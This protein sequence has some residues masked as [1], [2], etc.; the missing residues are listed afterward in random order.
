MTEENIGDIHNIHNIQKNDSGLISLKQ[1]SQISGYTLQHLSHLCREEKLK[2]VR[3]GKKWFTTQGWIKYYFK[4]LERQYENNGKQIQAE[5]Q[6][7]KFSNET[8]EIPERIE[9]PEKK[10]FVPE[11][12]P[13]KIKIPFAWNWNKIG[14]GFAMAGMAFLIFFSFSA[15]FPQTVFSQLK[16]DASIIYPHAK[17]F[18]ARVYSS[19]ENIGSAFGFA[20]FKTSQFASNI[21]IEMPDITLPEIYLP[22]FNLPK[23]SLPEIHLPQLSFS[24]ISEFELPKVKLPDISLPEIKLP[25]Y[26]SLFE[27]A[28]RQS[29]QFG[30]GLYSASR[31][32]LDGS[33]KIFS[34]AGSAFGSAIFKTSQFVSNI[35]FQL[36]AFEISLSEVHPVR[37]QISKISD[38]VSNLISNGVRLPQLSFSWISEFELPEIKLPKINLSKFSFSLLKLKDSFKE[39]KLFSLSDIS[40]SEIKIPKIS[41]KQIFSSLVFGIDETENKIQL[42]AVS[43]ASVLEDMGG[44]FWES[45]KTF[46]L[47]VNEALE[48]GTKEI[49]NYFVQVIGGIKELAIKETPPS[50]FFIFYPSAEKSGQAEQEPQKPETPTA[51]FSLS[52]LEAVKK[53]LAALRQSG[54]KVEQSVAEWNLERILAGLTPEEIDIKLNQL[55]NKILAQIADLKNLVALRTYS[56]AGATVASNFQAIALTQRIDTLS[57]ATINNATITGTLSGLTDDH[58]PDDITAS[59]YLLLTGG[60][61]T[62]TLSGISIITTGN[63]GIGTTSPYSLLSISN[64]AA[65]AVNTPLFTVASTTAGV[66]TT[67]LMTILA[68]GNVGINTAEPLYKLDVIG[69]IRLSGNL[70]FG[71]IATTTGSMLPSSDNAYDLGSESS[72]WRDI[73]ISRNALVS[74]N[75]GIGSTTP[76][77]K[78]SVAGSG[79]FDGGT[80]IASGFTATSSITAPYFTATGNTASTFPYASS[81]F[82]TASGT[83]STTNLISSGYSTLFFASTTQLTTSGTAS[84]TN[85]VVSGN[86]YLS[87]MTPSSIL[88]AGTNGLISQNNPNLNWNNTTN[89]LAV[90]GN[91]STTQIG[92]TDSAY[93]ATASGNVGIGTTSPFAKLS[94]AGSGYFDGNLTVSNITATG[95]LSTF[96]FSATNASTTNLD[97]SGYLIANNASSTITN[98][99]SVFASSTAITVSETASTTNLVVSG[100]SALGSVQSAIMSLGSDAS[101]DIYYRNSSGYLTRLAGSATPGYI[102]AYNAN[103]I[104]SW[105]ATTTLSTISGILAVGSGGTGQSTFTSSQLLYGNGTAALSSVGTSSLAVDLSLLSSGTLGSQIGGTASSLSLNMANANT[106]TA[107]QTFAY[108][109]STG[110]TSSYASSTSG[111]FGNLYLGADGQLTS[112]VGQGLSVS[113]NKLTVNATTSLSQLATV[114]IITTGIWNATPITTPYGGTGLGAG[115]LEASRIP[116]GNGTSAFSTSTN[117]SFTDPVLTATY[118]SSTGIS[119]TYSSSTLGYIGTLTLNTPLTIT[120]GGTGQSTFTSSQLLYGNGTAALSSVAT[121]SITVSSPLAA[122]ASLINVGAASTLSCNTASGSA[123]GCLASADYNIFNNKV[124]TSSIDSILDINTMLVGEDVASTTWAGATSIVTVGDLTAGSLGVGFTD[125][126]VLQGGTGVSSFTANNLLYSNS[127]GTALAYT[128][129]STATASAPLVFSNTAFSVIGAATTNLTCSAASGSAAG[130]LSAANWNTF[131]N[132]VGTS[133][134]ETAGYLAY[135]TTTSG[136]P[137]LI[138]GVATSSLAIGTSLSNTGTLGSQIGGTA[139]SLSLNMANANTWTALQTFAYASTT[140]ISSSQGATFATVSGNVGI[141][142]TGPQQILEVSKA[143]ASGDVFSRF[144]NSSGA[145]YGAGIEFYGAYTPYPSVTSQIYSE[146]QGGGGAGDRGGNLTM[147]YQD[148]NGTLQTGIVL[149]KNGNVGIGTTNPGAATLKIGGTTDLTWAGNVLEGSSGLVTIGTGGVTGGS[150]L[151]VTPSTGTLWQSGLGI[152]GTYGTP[153]NRSVININAYGTK[154]SG[155]GSDLAFSTTNGAT[156]YERMRI[157]NSGNVGIGTTTPGATLDVYG[158]LCV[159]DTSPTCANAARSAGYIYAVGTTI[160]GIDVAEQYPTKDADL[161]AGEILSIDEANPIYVKRA[162]TGSKIIGIVSTQPGVLLGGYGIETFA[163]ETKVSVALSGRVPVKV[164]LEGGEINIGDRIILSSVSGIGKKATTSGETVG[165]ALQPFNSSSSGDSILVFIN[166]KQNIFESQFTIDSSGNIGIG[167]TTPTHKLEVAGEVAAL[168]FINLSTEQAKKDIVFLNNK[169]DEDIL[170]KIASTN[171]ATYMYRDEECFA[172][173]AQNCS[174][175]LG[176]IAELA[177]PEILSVDGKGVDLYKMTSFLWSGIKAQ[178]NKLADLEL[179]IKNLEELVAVGVGTSTLATGGDETIITQGLAWVLEQ[180]KNIGVVIADGVIQ[181]QK[182]VA[183]IIQTKE[184]EIGSQEAP[185]GF[186]IYDKITKEPYCVSLENGEFVKTKGKCEQKPTEVRPPSAASAEVSTSNSTSTPTISETGQISTDGKVGAEAITSTPPAE[187]I[188]GPSAPS[189]PPEEPQPEPVVE[190][191]AP[192]PVVEPVPPP[193]PTVGETI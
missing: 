100:N 121:S 24:W 169:D 42:A 137:A 61:L 27:I 188:V 36:P 12:V 102:L 161:S 62:G 185:S 50:E 116:F 41:L 15:N 135:Y 186:T 81:T 111:Y 133:S 171:V 51:S 193:A 89:L 13:P 95:T 3:I 65:T 79:Y 18:S 106:W 83:A 87:Q 33:E 144:S 39:V 37:N 4:E 155:Y 68:N 101:G 190:S 151:V 189:M 66:S 145:G 26:S 19:A 97:I 163:G 173:D 17:N 44:I 122:S 20:I 108:A 131:N 74:G 38:K 8:V 136:T 147:K 40:F 93:F 90:L 16:N 7:Q 192:E 178:E 5:L 34:G 96:N 69:D 104:P 63:V 60:A 150:L 72:H 105:E 181:A 120:N 123:A 187:P 22:K 143:S 170:A 130:C 129:T 179:R 75:I 11:F 132:K 183:N 138:G 48:S 55:N 77:Y 119:N 67:T 25:D 71:G 1:A 85:L 168:G 125:V 114:G 57:G 56:S 52:E 118:A 45:I 35:D 156:L 124:S 175:R 110:I 172:P 14:L 30:T 94:V 113:G 167:T 82:I 134:S 166:L 49:G 127:G 21:D 73:W 142:T 107:L 162:T 180:F 29:R 112:F 148:V 47:A 88:F 28:Y 128:A 10:I 139:S 43:S 140:G 59:R 152:T 70:L 6:T 99:H 159:D 157:D 76:G 184:L 154:T 117:L 46:S 109:S 84:T 182:F 164:N 32:V 146:P 165:I 9:I 174:K 92:S 91:A 177:P 126:P 158:A 54:L 141:G 80:I 103:N 176:L 58:I 191:T 2:N 98:L 31:S 153:T 115:G 160:T 149:Q 53:E 64:S 78:L 23:F 86:Q